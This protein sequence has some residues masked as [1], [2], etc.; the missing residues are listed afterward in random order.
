MEQESRKG[1]ALALLIELERNLRD[2]KLIT[3]CKEIEELAKQGK[4]INV[5]LQVV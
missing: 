2:P 5:R 3:V 1:N 4:T